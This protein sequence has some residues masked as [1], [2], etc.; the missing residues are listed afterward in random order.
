MNHINLQLS[1]INITSIFYYITSI[2]N[3]IN[4]DIVLTI[5]LII[6]TLLAFS[7]VFLE[8]QTTTSSW[9]WILVLFLIPYLGFILYLIF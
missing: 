9:A 8:Y 7:I 2:F 1:N 5:F 3:D 4:F 6:N